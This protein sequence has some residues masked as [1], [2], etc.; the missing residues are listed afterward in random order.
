MGK[1]VFKKQLAALVGLIFIVALV[2]CATLVKN[3]SRTLSVASIAYE[4]SMK[5]ANELYKQ[6]K[7][8]EE[9]K[10]KILEIANPYYVAYHTASDALVAYMAVESEE[11]EEKLSLAMVEFSKVLGN[12]MAYVQPLLME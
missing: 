1:I 8:T 2:S 9:E 4:V 10:V 6:G 7:I 12:F 3:S 11:N 5:S